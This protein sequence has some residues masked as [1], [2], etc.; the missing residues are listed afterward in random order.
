MSLLKIISRGCI[1]RPGDDKNFNI[2][3]F[4]CL[5]ILPSGRWLASFRAAEKK[6]DC[7]FMHAVMTWSD[8]EGKSWITPF[9]PVKLPAI[10]EIPG[11]GRILYFL[12]LG[13]RRVLMVT[14][15]VDSSELSK[16]YYDPENESLKDTRI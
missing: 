8:D 16:P 14:N 4:P 3:A 12:S 9:E 6:G 5:V 10:C 7:D 1:S 11:Q 15:W 13:E 2:N